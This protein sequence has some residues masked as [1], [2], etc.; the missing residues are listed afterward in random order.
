MLL[1]RRSRKGNA[2]PRPPRCTAPLPVGASP[3]TVFPPTLPSPK[4]RSPASPGRAAGLQGWST[5]RPSWQRS[6]EGGVRGFHLASPPSLCG[7]E[8]GRLSG[9]RWQAG[10]GG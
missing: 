5:E 7:V 1:R 4:S 6:G 8:N 3:R 9:W 10:P 2:L